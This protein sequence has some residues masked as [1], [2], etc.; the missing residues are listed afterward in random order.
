MEV[1]MGLAVNYRDEIRNLSKE[2]SNDKLKELVDFAHFLKVK[3]EGFTY[4]AVR[5][6]TEY[7]KK[8]RTKEGERT[9]SGKKFIEELIEWQKS[10]Y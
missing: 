5:D 2:L 7:V 8:M 1:R 6:S 4:Q 9:K 3:E 10:N